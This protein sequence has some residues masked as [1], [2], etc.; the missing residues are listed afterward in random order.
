MSKIVN[1]RL[2]N[3]TAQYS[4]VQFDQLVRVLEQII[5][6]LNT[7]YTPTTSEDTSAAM[8]W[9]AGSGGSAGGGFAGAIRGFQTSAGI[10]MP[11]GMFMDTDDQES[12]GITSENILTFNT[13]VLSSGVRIAAHEAEFTA[14][15]TTTT[16]TV[17]AVASGS[18]LPG[19]VLTGTGVTAGTRIVSQS[20]GTA[21]GAGDYVVTIS[22]TVASTAVQG[23]RASKIVF[24]Y[25][26]EYSVSVSV[27]VTNQD[28]AI[29][30]FELWAKNK[31]VNYP[32]SNT[33]FDV[34]VRKSATIWGHTAAAITG[35]F[36]VNDPV[37]DYLEMA[38]WSNS[39]EVHV[40]HYAAGTNP[41]RPEIPSIILTASFVSAPG[42]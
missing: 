27:Q 6:Q 26:G 28:N 24:D 15:I 4:P 30:E 38:W 14:S 40:E 20:T 9:S 25:P 16:M 29:H 5:F 42:A 23:S 8:R 12:L 22:Q 7:T 37:S 31:G 34:P 19:M 18:L 39:T 1:V 36:T 21:G 13:S 10:Q 33:R 3:A 35:T 41:T 2:P 17:T 11:Y 32:L